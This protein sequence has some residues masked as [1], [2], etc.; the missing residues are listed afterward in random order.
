MAVPGSVRSPASEGTNLLLV[1]GA[2][3]AVDSLDVLVALGLEAR[4]ALRRR[5]DRRPKP[6]PADRGLLELFGGDALTLDTVLLRSGRPLPEVAL[7]LGRL[8]AGGWLVRAPAPGTSGRAPVPEVRHD[9]SV[10]SRVCR[11]ASR[12]SATRSP[13][14][15]RTPSLRTGRISPVS[16]PG[17]SGPAWTIPARWTGS[18]CVATWPISPLAA[19]RPAAGP[20]R[21]RPCGATSAGSITR[22]RCPTIRPVPCGRREG[23]AA[24]R[25]CW[26]RPSWRYC[27]TRRPQSAAE[28]PL[29]RRLRDDAVLEVLYGGGLRVGELCGLDLP[30]VA[31]RTRTLTVWGKGGKQRQVP[32]G[33]PAADALDGWLRRGRPEFLSAGPTEAP[34]PTDGAAVFF[35]QRHRRLTPRD[36]R[37]ILDRRAPTPT[38][39]HAL[40]HSYATHLLDGGR[41]CAWCRSCSAT[42][43][44]P[45]PRST[46]T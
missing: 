24:C 17:W 16:P 40:R 6:E 3:P 25:A 45:P 12:S 44:W 19:T 33:Q 32:L 31:L 43:T 2:A 26:P 8:E 35:N 4:P 27:W 10:R 41:T 18:R 13:T 14:C 21:L 36:V 30:D 38:H 29:A 1:D 7:S 9:R 5:R 37:R 42:P 46:P 23:T 11:G 39:P 34:S 28:E 20:G 22:A 15:H